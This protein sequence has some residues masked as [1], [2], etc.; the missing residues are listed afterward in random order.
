MRQPN[1]PTRNTNDEPAPTRDDAVRVHV[2][3]DENNAVR[4]AVVD[5]LHEAAR[6]W[7]RAPDRIARAMREARGLNSAERRFASEAVFA[8]VRHHRRLAFLAGIDEET[9]EPTT[10]AARLLEMWLRP[11]A[12]ED[13]RLAAIADPIR[14]VAVSASYPDWIVRR[15]AEGAGGLAGAA[16]L[17][18]AM[19]RRGPL[20]VRCNRL[21]GTREALQEELRE[22]GIASAPTLLA[23]DGLVLETRRNVYEM[24]PF[25]EGWME[26]Q[27]EGSQLV[28]ELVAPPP[29]GTVID[30]CAGAGGKTLALGALLANRGRLVSFDISATKLVELRKRARRAGLT[31][32]HALEVEPQSEAAGAARSG[33]PPG[34]RPASRVL[35]DAPCSG[36][37]VVRRNPE[38]KWR[39]KPGDL[40]EM[41]RK[42]RAILEAYAPLVEPGG[43]L[44]YATCSV[45]PEE[46]DAV[47]ASFLAANP[48]FEQVPVKEIWG[49]ARALATGDGEVLRV[50]PQTHDTDG[51]YAAVLRRRR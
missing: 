5:L 31:D 12:D 3:S 16:E 20:T 22:L 46:N 24:A 9:A 8:L 2:L 15:L 30:A 47:V 43:R 49:T 27:D 7:P 40:D 33:P 28:A 35:V 19:N 10:N 23:S 37:G 21:K 26:L 32:V 42:Q 41:P 38:T 51:F 25:R 36:L 4:R 39:V 48:A 1:L 34:T 45:F 50:L 14:R 6:D 18:T 44:I 13:E 29:R 17:L 11:P